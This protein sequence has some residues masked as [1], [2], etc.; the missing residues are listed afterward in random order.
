[1]LAEEFMAAQRGNR[2]NKRKYESYMKD[3]TDYNT[4][5]DRGRSV[6]QV[7]PNQP[8]FSEEAETL[9]QTNT[10]DRANAYERL[11]KRR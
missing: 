4:K 9:R 1:M 5:V 3:V 11:M 2:R 10:L 6:R 7:D 8:A